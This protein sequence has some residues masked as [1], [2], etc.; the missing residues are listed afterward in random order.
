MMNRSCLRKERL[1]VK[2]KIYRAS[3][4]CGGG[5]PAT[6]SAAVE[7]HFFTVH[8]AVLRYLGGDDLSR[9]DARDLG[10]YLCL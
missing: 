8:L 6:I 3:S 5:V 1:R 7:L 4:Q 2:D 10:Y 9:K